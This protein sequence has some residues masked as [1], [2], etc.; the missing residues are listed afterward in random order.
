MMPSW[1][2]KD[3]G[4]KNICLVFSDKTSSVSTTPNQLI[5]HYRSSFQTFA[6]LTE[7]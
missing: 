3:T 4:I 5:D 6:K 1:L 7:L 2:V